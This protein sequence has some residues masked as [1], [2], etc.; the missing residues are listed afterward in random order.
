[1]TPDQ[2]QVL[3]LRVL[4]HM[5]GDERALAGFLAQSG[6]DR[7]SLMQSANDPETLAGALDYLLADERLLLAFCEAE[8]VPPETPARARAA[9][10]GA[11]PEW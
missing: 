8:A 1:M 4:A 3:A 5:A 7:D 11:N 2:A 9:L 6:M 10:P